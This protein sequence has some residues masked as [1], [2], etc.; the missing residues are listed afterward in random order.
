MHLH[1]GSK[2][3]AA[4]MA[5]AMDSSGREYLVIVAKATWR[6]PLP[7]ERP[8]PLPPESIALTDQYYGPPGESPLRYGCDMV[9]H[10]ALC[11]VL[12]DA[13]AHSPLGRPVRE[14]L[15]GFDLGP[16][17][18][19]IRVLG[20]RQWLSDP[21]GRK[22]RLGPMSDFTAVPLHHGLAFGGTR[23]YNEGDAALCDTFEDN[24]VGKGFAGPK[25]RAL[26]HLQ[27]AHQLEW[28]GQSVSRPD[29]AV[30]P[31]ALSAVGRDWRPR[32][33]YA[34]TY[35]E[36]WQR[37]VFPLLPAD[38]DERFHQ[39][40]PADQQMPYPEGGETVRLLQLMPGRPVVEFRLPRFRPQISV[41]RANTLQV[42]L[43]PVMDTLFFETEAQRFSAVWRAV[44]P[45]RRGLQEF[46]A[47]AVGATDPGLW[48]P[49]F[50][51]VSGGCD[52][53]HPS[54]PLFS[55]A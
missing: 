54:P 24:P 40:A 44:I 45:M 55:A 35:D 42:P 14:L 37:D 34:G 28:P 20:P 26:I 25:T 12:F 9:R 4:E 18:K 46:E 41:L 30:T 38:F 10:K 6:I 29:D 8:R 27:P 13:Q 36:A 49:G 23:H 47:C 17:S 50:S 16:L 7:G 21:R 52:G 31:A 2:H 33:Q 32:R 22:I 15:V 51:N 43:A 11:D 39:C 5:A 3:L 19:R 53:C 48:A 1:L